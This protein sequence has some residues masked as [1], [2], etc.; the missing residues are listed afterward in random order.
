MTEGTVGKYMSRFSEMCLK[1]E[2]KSEV[3]FERKDMENGDSND[4]LSQKIGRPYSFSMM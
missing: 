4:D 1:I 2:K 3:A